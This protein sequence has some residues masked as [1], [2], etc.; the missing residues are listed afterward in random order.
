MVL[1]GGNVPHILVDRVSLNNVRHLLLQTEQLSSK[2]LRKCNGNYFC[3]P[4]TE[5]RR[6]NTLTAQTADISRTFL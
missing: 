4:E 5:R 6:Q 2:N 3:M 1:E